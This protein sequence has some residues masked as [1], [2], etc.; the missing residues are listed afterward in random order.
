MKRTAIIIVAGGGGRRT[1]QVAVLVHRHDDRAERGQEDRVLV[2]IG[3]RIEQIDV[4][5]DRGPV[6]VLAGTVDACE[7]FLVQQH[8]E[9]MLT[10]HLLHQ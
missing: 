7:G 4:A 8:A 2:G 1:Q 10:S 6:V 3:S 5:V 9:T